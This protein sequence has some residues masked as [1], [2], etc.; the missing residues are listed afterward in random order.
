M[1]RR[2]AEQPSRDPAATPDGEPVE[3]TPRGPARQLLAAGMFDQEFYEAQTGE[4]FDSPLQAARHAVAT[5]MPQR[6]SPHP[7]LDFHAQ[8]TRVRR[9]WRAGKVRVMLDRIA[10]AGARTDD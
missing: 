1:F 4:R 3:A 9:P 8:P 10:S 7:S 6:L 5:G 2:R